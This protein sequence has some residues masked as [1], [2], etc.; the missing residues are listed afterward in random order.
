MND[1]ARQ[2]GPETQGAIYLRGLSGAKPEI[3]TNF[4]GLE[5]A[6]QQKMSPEAWAYTAGSAGLETAAEANRAAFARYPIAPRVL[7][8][9]AQRNLG[10][11]IFGARVAAP[12][13]SSP[14]GVLEMMH[15]DADL[16]VARAKAPQN[17]PKIN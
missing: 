10:A 11:E 9:A 8:G 4:V 16:A 3:P 13:F 7:A 15:P 17:Q 14:I 12:V 6:A 5:A 2:F 1:A